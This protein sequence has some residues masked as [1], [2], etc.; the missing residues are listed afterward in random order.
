MH[1]SVDLIKVAVSIGGIPVIRNATIEAKACELAAIVGE[2]GAGKTTLL[3][4]V[5]GTLKPDSGK[6][7]VFGQD[8]ATCRNLNDVRKQIAVVPQKSNHHDFPLRVE[9]AV[10]MGRYGK[11]GIMRRPKDEDRQA[12]VAAMKL[13]R[14][15]PFAKKLVS[16]LS[17]GEQQKV[18]LARALAQEPEILLL[19]EPTTY[20]DASSREEIMETIHTLHHERCLT[21]LMVSHDEESVRQYADKVYLLKDGSSTLI[22]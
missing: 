22:A 15:L 5:N 6:V 9:E 7:T 10:L 1:H 17:G 3:R 2:N 11:M 21:T 12:A 13:T 14:I 16:E 8:L 4:L 20:L 18:S 19:D